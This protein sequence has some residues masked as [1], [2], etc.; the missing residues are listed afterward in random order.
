MAVPELIELDPSPAAVVRETVPVSDL[1]DFFGRALGAVAATVAGQ[2]VELVGEPFAFYAGAPTDV[3]EVAAGFRVSAAFEPAG[4]VVPMELP[5]GP[6]VTMVYVGPYDSM[7]EAY[8]EM[9]RWMA[10]KGLTPAGHMWESYLTD[11]GE[12]PD[13]SAWRTK[14]VW[15]V[16]D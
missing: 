15:P 11:P 7:D 8:H 14:I 4:D 6:A 10:A 2:G 16:D 5:G 13:P 12:E 1:S 9:H 3:V